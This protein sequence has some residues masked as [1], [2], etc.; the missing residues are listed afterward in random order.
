LKN[1]YKKHP[2]AYIKE[3]IDFY[4]TQDELNKAEY[5]II[6]PLLDNNMCLNLRD[7]GNIGTFS[8]ES[9][10]KM[11]ESM[12]GKNKGHIPWNKGKHGLQIVWNKG[13]KNCFSEE[14]RKKLSESHKGLKYPNR[15]SYSPSEETRK[16]ISELHKG[17]IISEE[18]RHKQSESMK[19]KNIGHI[20]WNKNI[21]CFKETKE[22]ISKANKGRIYINNGIINKTCYKEELEH[23]LN[24]GWKKGRIKPKN[25]EE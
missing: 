10:K 11:S 9:I 17:K 3:I 21:P 23:Y 14:T 25:N 6:H 5:D 18:T 4:D 19:G 2:N 12:K 1:Y 24:E 7:G 16:K 20:P 15:K 22:K 13:I 8:E